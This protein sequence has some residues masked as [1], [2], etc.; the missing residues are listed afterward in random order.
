MN[1]LIWF[2]TDTDFETEWKTSNIYGKIKLL[3]ITGGFLLCEA[4]TFL[5]FLDLIF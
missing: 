1:K 4:L 5:F 2:L 3:Y